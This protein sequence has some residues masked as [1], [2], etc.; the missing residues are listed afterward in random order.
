MS[1]RRNPGPKPAH[2]SALS[3][4]SGTL[5]KIRLDAEIVKEG[6]GRMGAICADVLTRTGLDVS[7]SRQALWRGLL[8]KGLSKARAYPRGY[9]VNG[10]SDSKTTLVDIK[11]T[12]EHLTLL[13]DH[14]KE[15]CHRRTITGAV[16]IE[17]GLKMLEPQPGTPEKIVASIPVALTPELEHRAVAAR[18]D[19]VKGLASLT[20]FVFRVT[21]SAFLRAQLQRALRKLDNVTL[22]GPLPAAPGTP[23]KNA[24][25]IPVTDAQR[26]EV[27][28][29]A[30]LWGMRRDEVIRRVLWSILPE[31]P[32]GEE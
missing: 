6:L 25:P 21:D 17:R 12:P 32:A 1:R 8:L 7:L 24:T 23:S 30:T 16:A 28:H 4:D 22:H 9:G 26:T 20:Q 3:N 27:Q 5:V 31:P 18:Q 11:L 19:T 13:E 10:W 15:V 2:Q 14:A 29:L